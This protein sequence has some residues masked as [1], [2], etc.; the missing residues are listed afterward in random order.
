MMIG[1]YYNV[2]RP[3]GAADWQLRFGLSWI[4]P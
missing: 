3:D 2:V 1:P 4:F